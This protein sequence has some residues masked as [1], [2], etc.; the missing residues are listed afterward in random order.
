MSAR[1]AISRNLLRPVSAR[2]IRVAPQSARH[3]SL[4]ASTR[5][6]IVERAPVSASKAWAVSGVRFKSTDK[7]WGPPIVTYEELKPLTEQPSDVSKHAVDF[8]AYAPS[9]LSLHHIS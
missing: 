3:L 8:R 4:L 5:T 7:A 2:A 1:T 6:S 9:L